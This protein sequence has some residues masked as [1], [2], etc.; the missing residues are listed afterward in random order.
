[1]H[2][3]GPE[4]GGILVP[5]TLGV[6]PMYRASQIA[7]SM[8]QIFPT[9]SQALVKPDGPLNMA[10]KWL[11]SVLQCIWAIYYKGELSWQ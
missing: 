11:H 3:T 1:M 2:S 7:T 9:S 5:V 6:H 4:R 10:L 8:M